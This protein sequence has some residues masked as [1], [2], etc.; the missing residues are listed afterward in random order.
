MLVIH[1]LASVRTDPILSNVVVGQHLRP[2]FG[3]AGII[4]RPFAIRP[5]LHY[6]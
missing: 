3:L 6:I 2:F 4:G 5:L 1:Q